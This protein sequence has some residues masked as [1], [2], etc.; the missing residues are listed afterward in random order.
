ME[1]PT[2]VIETRSIPVGDG[3]LEVQMTQAFIDKIRQHFGLLDVEK[4]DDDHVRMY[5]WGAVSSAV[6]KAEG[7][8]KV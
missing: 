5:L 8:M 3:T 2:N 6:N 7:S 1:N 4:I